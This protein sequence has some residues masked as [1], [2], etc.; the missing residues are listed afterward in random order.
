MVYVASGYPEFYS[1]PG[2]MPRALICDTF[3]QAIPLGRCLFYLMHLRFPG[4]SLPVSRFFLPPKH[5][6]YT[7]IL[8]HFYISKKFQS[9]L[10][11]VFS[12]FCD[13]F[14]QY[15]TWKPALKGP[16]NPARG[17]APG[18]FITT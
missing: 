10:H 2:A 6:F 9:S 12:R 14:N 11:F 7:R 15:P 4:Y 17:S 5:K 1:I 16:D 18:L 8:I 3:G 13:Q